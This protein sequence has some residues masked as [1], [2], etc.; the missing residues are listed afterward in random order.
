MTRPLNSQIGIPTAVNI[1]AARFRS[2]I[3]LKP[4]D[5]MFRRSIFALIATVLLVLLGAVNA[6]AA[7][8]HPR[9]QRLAQAQVALMLRTF[10]DKH[11]SAPAT[12]ADS[13]VTKSVFLLPTLLFPSNTESVPFAS[14]IFTC[15]TKAHSVLVDLGGILVAEDA[16]GDPAFQRGNLEKTCADALPG[17]FPEN[18]LPLPLKVD[19][20]PV[21]IAQRVSTP[22]F[23]VT[24]VNPES[25]PNYFGASKDLGHPGELAVAYCGFKAEVKLHNGVHQISVDL[26][27]IV[28]PGAS[29]TYNIRVR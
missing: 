3:N 28:S 20:R 5:Q 27:S 10:D 2:T 13:Q 14:Q 26:S 24:G 15:K 18:A 12:C 29:F 17:V 9:L 4:G 16:S 8:G 11:W 22:E 7:T 19:G 1:G 21:S 6:N 25:G 23:I